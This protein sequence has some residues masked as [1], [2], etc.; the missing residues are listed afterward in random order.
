MKCV[1][2]LLN[3]TNIDQEHEHFNEVLGL[4]NDFE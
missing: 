3:A 4:I 1:D 2:S